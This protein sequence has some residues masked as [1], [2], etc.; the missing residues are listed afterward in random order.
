MEPRPTALP[1][2][3][4]LPLGLAWLG[5]NLHGVLV[6]QQLAFVGMLLT[7]AWIAL[8]H[9]VVRCLIFPLLFLFLGVPVGEG[10]I[11]PMINFT[12]DFTV[13]MLRLTGI[14]VSQH[15]VTFVIP[16]GRWSVI[17]TCSGHSYLFASLTLGLLFA[18]MTYTKWWK[19]SLFVLASIL[20]PILANGLRAYAIVM[21]GHLSDMK[22]AVGIDHLI[23]GWLFFSVMIAVMFAVGLIWADPPPSPELPAPEIADPPSPTRLGVL[24]LA[25]LAAAGAWP[26]L[27]WAI[28]EA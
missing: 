26:A 5:A 20:A 4:F 25:L 22:L 27:A 21:I 12:A 9:R 3:L 14:P 8:G 6:V 17:E 10:L 28:G 24:F 18:Y 13:G 2:F 16:T 1:F 7:T 23:Y 19:R 11:Q 15:G